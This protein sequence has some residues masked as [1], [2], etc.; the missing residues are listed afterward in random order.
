MPKPAELEVLTFQQDEMKRVVGP[1]KDTNNGL[2]FARPRGS[3]KLYDDQRP[4]EPGRPF[5]GYF[6]AF[7]P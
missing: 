4:V 7:I 2:P 5:V 1:D 6:G 3:F